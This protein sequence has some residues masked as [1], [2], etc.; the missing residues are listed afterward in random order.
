[1][2]VGNGIKGILAPPSVESVGLQVESDTGSC[3][4]FS[5]LSLIRKWERA[6]LPQG[7]DPLDAGGKG[8]G[9]SDSETPL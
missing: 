6:K 1:M 5:Q 3:F 7:E 9:T 4:P 2:S 8:P